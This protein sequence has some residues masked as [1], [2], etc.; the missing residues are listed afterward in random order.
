[1]KGFG[2][3]IS[4]SIKHLELLAWK[5][6]ELWPFF[7]FSQFSVWVNS[8]FGG[9]LIKEILALDL[10][11]EISNGVLISIESKLS[12]ICF[13][14]LRNFRVSENGDSSSARRWILPILMDT[15]DSIYKLQ[16]VKYC[17]DLVGDFLWFPENLSY[18]QSFCSA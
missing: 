17:I 5:K 6:P 1:M 18:L 14:I 8:L 15:L 16:T 7:Q 9:A 11:L 3:L 10:I 4:T 2:G 12:T 13:L